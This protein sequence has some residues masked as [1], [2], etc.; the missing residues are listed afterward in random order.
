MRHQPECD[1]RRRAARWCARSAHTTEAG[2]GRTG[3]D[4]ASVRTAGTTQHCGLCA[5]DR[6]S[7][8]SGL[9]AC[10][11]RDRTS[12]RAGEESGQGRWRAGSGG[13]S[14][15]TRTRARE[16]GRAWDELVQ[17][18][19]IRHSGRRKMIII[20][21]FEKLKGMCCGWCQARCPWHGRHFVAGVAV[22]VGGAK[23]RS[24]RAGQWTIAAAPTLS[25]GPVGHPAR[26][27][28]ESRAHPR[29]RA[30]GSSSG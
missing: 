3:L 13:K 15:R 8:W 14:A 10:R 28:E 29:A 23:R 26:G 22:A 2:L 11:S 1:E 7:Y 18:W 27:V 25:M 4:C 16:P 20:K 24:G 30:Q 9:R 5:I 17:V 6:S 12:L 21:P 19:H